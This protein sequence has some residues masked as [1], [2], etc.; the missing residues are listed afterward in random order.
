LYYADARRLTVVTGLPDRPMARS[1][2]IEGL[3]LRAVAITDDG[4]AAY[5]VTDDGHLFLAG[6]TG[7][8]RSTGIGGVRDLRVRPNSH[9]AAVVIEGDVA[10]FS[11]AGLRVIAASL[12]EPRAIEFSQDGSRVFIATADEIVAI[13]TTGQPIASVAMGCQSLALTR[14]NNDSVLRVE[15]EGDAT[16]RI[17]DSAGAHL[18]VLF[19]PAFSE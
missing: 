7:V 12:N 4:A 10:L 3:E 5:L 19:V 11:S 8:V 1:S 18:R 2:A 16:V 13:T 15:C 14:M 9:E 6:D 17:I